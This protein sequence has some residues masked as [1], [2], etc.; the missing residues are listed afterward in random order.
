MVAVRVMAPVKVAL[1]AA[2]TYFALRSPPRTPDDLAR[3]SCVRT[4]PRAMSW[5]L[6]VDGKTRR[7][8]VNGPLIVNNID[9][10]VRAAV[11]GLGIAYAAEAVVEPFLRS[12]QLVRVLEKWSPTL[13]GVVLYYPGR[14]QV[15]AA[16]RAFIDMIRTP[17]GA[18]GGRSARRENAK[19]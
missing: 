11:D 12:G 16:L 3:H 15:P 19:S 18:A 5:E 14:R 9:L 2:P 10:S 8:A 4:R 1:V 6:E 13:E 7:V 17:A